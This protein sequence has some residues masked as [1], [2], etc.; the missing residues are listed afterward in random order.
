M[1]VTR[2]SLGQLIH[3]SLPRRRISDSL[4][5]A[6]CSPACNSLACS[7]LQGARCIRLSRPQGSTCPRTPLRP[8]LNRSLKAGRASSL[9]QL[10]NGGALNSLSST[11]GF[12][13]VR[14]VAPD[15][16]RRVLGG[17]VPTLRLSYLFQLASLLGDPVSK[18]HA[19]L[20]HMILSDIA[21][22]LYVLWVRNI[23]SSSLFMGRSGW[24]PDASRPAEATGTMVL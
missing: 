4:A 23:S 10:S 22:L 13:A 8:S 20:A 3:P 14:E 19:D 21:R 7:I 17:P 12:D 11:G 24:H 6:S 15:R 1:A 18:A 5:Q 9:R 2:H 16:K